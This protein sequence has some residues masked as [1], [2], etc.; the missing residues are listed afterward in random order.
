MGTVVLHSELLNLPERFAFKFREKKV[1]LI[2]SGDSIT[3]RIQTKKPPC[4][5]L[6]YQCKAAFYT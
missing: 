4:I 3:L 2:E 6:I 1:E 5:G